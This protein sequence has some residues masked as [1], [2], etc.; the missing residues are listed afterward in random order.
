MILRVLL[1]GSTLILLTLAASVGAAANVEPNWIPFTGLENV[2]A[3][4]AAPHAA[5]RSYAV[6][7][8]RLY[9]GVGGAWESIAA[10]AGVIVNAVT[11][12]R[13]DADTVIIGAANKLSVFVSR[14]AGRG[15]DGDSDGD[16]RDWRRHR[17]GA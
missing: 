12:D 4:T 2:R 11:V 7:G 17:A 1:T 10:P 13:A 5:G 16:G 8:G 15:V 9:G 14:N 3:Y 6:D